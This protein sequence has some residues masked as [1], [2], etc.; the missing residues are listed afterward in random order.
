V[1]PPTASWGNV[2]AN[3]QR[4]FASAVS[5]VLVPGF[6]IWSTVQALYMV[7]EGHRDTL[8]PRLK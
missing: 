8:D 7:A 1:E 6:F 5:L 3:A 4:Y 2:L